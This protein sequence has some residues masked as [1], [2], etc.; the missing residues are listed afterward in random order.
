MPI[1]A[2]VIG[3]IMF[4]GVLLFFVVTYRQPARADTWYERQVP[5]ER[6][7]QAMIGLG[8]MGIALIIA[9]YGLRIMYAGYVQQFGPIW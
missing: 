7:N 2:M 4:F 6:I 3:G 9:F 1:I 5:Q 8:L